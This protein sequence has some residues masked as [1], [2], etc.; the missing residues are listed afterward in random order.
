M[1]GLKNPWIGYIERSYEQAKKAI[2]D[3][4]PYRIPEIT[5]HTENDIFVK[6]ISIWCGILE[7]LNYYID[8]RA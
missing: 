7:Q 2:F 3:K 8:S 4:M 6:M 1:A 5:D